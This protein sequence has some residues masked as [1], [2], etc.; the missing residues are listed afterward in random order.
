[1][2]IY[3]RMALT[4]SLSEGFA[5]GLMLQSPEGGFDKELIIPFKID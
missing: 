2:T 5:I 4:V 1:M 3:V